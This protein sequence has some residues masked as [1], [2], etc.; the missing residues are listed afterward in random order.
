MMVITAMRFFFRF[1]PANKTKKKMKIGN[2]LYSMIRQG[3]E[4]I[5]IINFLAL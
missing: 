1:S 5:S 4:Y 3:Y 2:L